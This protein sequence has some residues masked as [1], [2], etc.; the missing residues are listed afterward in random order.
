MSNVVM[1][2]DLHLDRCMQKTAIH[3]TGLSWMPPPPPGTP[4]PS[5]PT[6]GSIVT[7]SGAICRARLYST[8]SRRA[9]S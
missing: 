2:A 4:F 8:F 9:L 6:F 1:L 3:S 5:T 7:H